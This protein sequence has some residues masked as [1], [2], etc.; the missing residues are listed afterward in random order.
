MKVGI[1]NLLYILSNILHS[2]V[3]GASIKYLVIFKGYHS[4]NHAPILEK[5]ILSVFQHVPFCLLLVNLK[6]VLAINKEYMC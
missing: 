3:G 4:T 2:V 5:S 1:I 6:E